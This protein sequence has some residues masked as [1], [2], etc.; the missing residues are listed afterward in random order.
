MVQSFLHMTRIAETEPVTGMPSPESGAPI[1]VFLWSDD[2]LLPEMIRATLSKQPNMLFVGAYG[3]SLHTTS[4]IVSSACDVLLVDPGIDMG[5]VEA[6]LVLAKT[7]HELKN[8]SFVM[9]NTHGG[10]SEMLSEIQSTVTRS[11]ARFESTRQGF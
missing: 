9:M 3:L 1:R 10:I 11:R 2:R 7:T 5:T 8:M 6:Q 4:R